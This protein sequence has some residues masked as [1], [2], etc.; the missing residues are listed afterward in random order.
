MENS[1]RANFSED[2]FHVDQTLGALKRLLQLGAR[3]LEHG[4]KGKVSPADRALPSSAARSQPSPSGLSRGASAPRR[5][6]A[7]RL[8]TQ[9]TL[10]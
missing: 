1:V 8:P 4:S 10:P 3:V 2:K 9:W 5:K 7:P 6:T